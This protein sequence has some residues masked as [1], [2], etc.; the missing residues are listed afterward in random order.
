MS[1][2][3]ALTGDGDSLDGVALVGDIIGLNQNDVPSKA[4]Y[5]A[6]NENEHFAKLRKEGKIIYAMGNHE[7]PMH[8]TDEALS[9]LSRKVFSEET[10][11]PPENDVVLSGYHFIT[12]SPSS[13]SG[14]L[15]EEQERYVIDRVTSALKES[16]E[17]PVFL[18]LH[19]PVDDTIF[20]SHKTECTSEE[21]EKFIK[22]EPRLVVIS[23]HTHY[24]LSDPQSIYQEAGSATFINTS[25]VSGGNNLSLP[26]ATER[27]YL[28]APSDAFVMNIDEK[29]NVVTIKR[30]YVKKD[31]P[32]FYGEDW[33]LDIP[34][35]VREKENPSLKAYKYTMAREEASLPP[36]FA[37]DAAVT[38]TAVS[39]VDATVTFPAAKPSGEGEDNAVAYYKIDVYNE[40]GDEPFKISKIISDYFLER[41]RE[42]ITY[43][44]FNLLPSTNWRVSVTPVNPWYK[45]G[46]SPISLEFA[47]REP[48]FRETPL[49]EEFTYSQRVADAEKK[50]TFT[51]WSSLIHVGASSECAVEYLVNIEEAGD[52]RFFIVGSAPGRVDCEIEI[53]KKGENDTPIS[54]VVCVNTGNIHSYK[55]LPFADVEVKKPSSYLIKITKKESDFTIGL[56]EVKAIKHKKA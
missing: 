5:A 53:T 2:I 51:D 17:R 14:K 23:G 36:E 20:G 26:Y 55:A 30:F 22:S 45:E 3:F 19:F 1:N 56:K 4:H 39:D 44:I 29:T 16:E 50:G 48:K 34:A 8:S 31:G 35:M 15:S 42:K 38:L 41:C 7:F 12:A 24:P 10:G 28:A 25:T 33:T 40:D 54:D 11:L 27:H 21:F 18:L 37:D 13:Y 32:V 43:T 49:D 52:Y 46:N 6:I 47:T 9:S